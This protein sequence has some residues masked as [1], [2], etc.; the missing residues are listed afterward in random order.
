MNVTSHFGSIQ[1]LLP[2]PFPRV[3]K[4]LSSDLILIITKGG[5]I[6]D[7]GEEGRKRKCLSHVVKRMTLDLHHYV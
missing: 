5:A 7:N 1:S 4:S 2:K 6:K 3:L